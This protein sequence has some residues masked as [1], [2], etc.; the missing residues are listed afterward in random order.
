MSR[1]GSFVR[2][3]QDKVYQYYN[4]PFSDLQIVLRQQYGPN[5]SY[6]IEVAKREY[7]TIQNDLMHDYEEKCYE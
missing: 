7:E 3:I 4:K 2:D 5:A 6:A 1:M